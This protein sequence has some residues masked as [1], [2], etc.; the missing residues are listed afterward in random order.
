MRL[1]LAAAL[2]GVIPLNV[3]DAELATNDPNG[4]FV[5]LGGTNRL[6]PARFLSEPERTSSCRV[7]YNTVETCPLVDR[8]VTD[9]YTTYN[10]PPGPLKGLTLEPGESLLSESQKAG[11]F[12]PNTTENLMRPKYYLIRN[13]PICIFSSKIYASDFVMKMPVRTISKITAH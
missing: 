2:L 9:P 8:Q 12:Y 6:R 7:E 5:L 13:H 4:L 11:L 10:P 3:T 1:G